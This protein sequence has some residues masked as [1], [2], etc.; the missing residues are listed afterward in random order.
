[1]G[2]GRLW[3][4]PTA[5]LRH[6]RADTRLRL[7]VVGLPR[8]QYHHAVTRPSSLMRTHLFLHTS[9]HTPTRHLPILLAA[10][11]LVSFAI[12]LSYLDHYLMDVDEVWSI[13][14]SLGSPADIWRW[15]PY[16]W[17]VLHYQIT[18]LWANLTGIHP[19]TMRLSSVLIE[20]LTLAL[21]ARL[22]RDLLQSDYGGLLAALAY[23]AFGRSLHN[24]ITVR[25]YV[26]MTLFI[27]LSACL[28]VRY[29]RRARFSRALP[30]AGSMA[31]AFY[32]H[33]IAAVPL[34]MLLWF[35]LS[36]YRVHALR[37]IVPGSLAALIAAPEIIA[38][39]RFVLNN[40]ARDAIISQIVP[41]TFP[42]AISRYA[43][44]FVGRWPEVWLILLTAV[45]LWLLVRYRL[46]ALLT[47]LW[48]GG[49]L[50]LLYYV[51]LPPFGSTLAVGGRHLAWLLIVPALW[52]GC[53]L[54]KL[55]R[56]GTAIGSVG[57]LFIAFT[58]IDAALYTIPTPHL[59][60]SVPQLARLLQPGDEVVRDPTLADA[61]PEAW[62]YFARVYF[63]NT[64]IPFS[65]AP[66]TRR[67]WYVYSAGKTIPEVYDL[68]TI[69]RVELASFGAPEMRFSLYAA[70]PDVLGVPFENGLRFNGAEILNAVSPSLPTYREGES[71]QVRLWWSVD[72]PTGLDYS[73]ALQITD[74]EGKL[75]AQSDNF[76][77]RSAPNS[78]EQLSQ[79]QPGTYHLD[80][81]SIILP[82]SLPTGEY[83]LHVVVYQ[84]WDGVRI[85]ALQ[86]DA[87]GRLAVG[88]LYIKAW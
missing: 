34:L 44:D 74:T 48:S 50:L 65:N 46:Q 8:G 53:G 22:G 1:M 70:P 33:P 77:A 42:E 43:S 12:R 81:R 41:L 67:V 47:L 62:D 9:P 6:P 24:A 59:L 52:I 29:L 73:L 17:G 20:L 76:D 82:N 31:A 84:W 68:V 16:D 14:Q 72:K 11:L 61:P 78:P 86:S 32:V 3:T 69:G 18:G 51:L 45:S 36:A 10:L 88:S 19:V 4:P 87:D 58:P 80:T 75:I 66:K 27:A 57:L 64:G 60:D 85:R 23:L 49:G 5:S 71:V 56:V 55:P 54:A 28:M 79:W 40:P 35:A 26:L 21:I 39:A 63:P 15:T 37:L 83:L 30:L 38:K 13:W 2:V 25:G 7:T